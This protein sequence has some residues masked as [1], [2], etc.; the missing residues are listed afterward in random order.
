[1]HRAKI[2]GIGMYVPEQVVNNDDLAELMD[3][4]DAWIQQRT[5]IRQ[6]RYA[7]DGVGTSDLALPAA[8]NAIRDAGI[9]KDEV[10]LILF[11]TLSPDHHFPGTCCYFQAK[12]G[13]HGVPA[14]DLRTQCTGFLYGL[15]IAS[16]FVRCGMY[17]NVLLGGAEVH[18]HA[19]DFS[20][21]G[22]DVT[23]L[24][25]DGAGAAIVSRAEPGESSELHSFHL[26]SDGRHADAL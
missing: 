22:R 18:S 5:G 15:A 3:T 7:A 11:A 8:E 1:M 17:R 24:F 26:H 19:L 10:D 2:S 25:G 4:S 13:L 16:S 20:T 23:V 9:D 12:L 14:L 6:R 21:A